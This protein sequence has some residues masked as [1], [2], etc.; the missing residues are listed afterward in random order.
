MNKCV[1]RTTGSADAMRVALLRRGQA[2]YYALST[3][4]TGNA[5]IPPPLHGVPALGHINALS[6]NALED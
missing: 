3:L 5:V 6:V 2:S 1:T 4:Q